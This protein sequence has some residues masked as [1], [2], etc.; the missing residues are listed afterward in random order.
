MDHVQNHSQ[1]DP[2]LHVLK[3][4]STIEKAGEKACNDGQRRTEEIKEPVLSRMS[5]A[6]DLFADGEQG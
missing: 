4:F 3:D 5:D 2:G 6:L 1:S